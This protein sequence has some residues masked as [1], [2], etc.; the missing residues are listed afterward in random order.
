MA[1]PLNSILPTNTTEYWVP[2]DTEELFN[3]NWAENEELLT[4]NGFTPGIQI[5]YTF[6]G[7][8][9][10]NKADVDISRSILALGCSF[11]FGTGHHIEDIWPTKVA[12]K[13]GLSVFNAGVP[14]SSSDTAFRILD[15]LIDEEPVAVFCLAPFD[16]RWEF[17]E[18]NEFKNFGLWGEWL[19]NDNTKLVTELHTNEQRNRLNQHKNLLA[20]QKLC[21]LYNIPFVLMECDM[22][23]AWAWP[24]FIEGDWARDLGHQGRI[25][26]D[27][28]ARRMNMQF[29]NRY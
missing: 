11:T 15:T 27:E 25:W 28:V 19:Y 2:G 17:I 26:H 22:N 14:G 9:L 18:D 13:L 29:L 12:K 3:K 16:N 10:R 8:A 21:D 7:Y 1:K 4:R 20:M 24:E 6:D 5:E 23:S